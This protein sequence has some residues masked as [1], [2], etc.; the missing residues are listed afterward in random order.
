[1]S[2]REAILRAKMYIDK[3]ANGIDPVTDKKIPDNE[4]IN[5]VKISRCLFFV[6][7]LLQKMA[8]GEGKAVPS[9]MN[10]P[11]QTAKQQTR[12]YVHKE[13]LRIS[14]ADKMKIALSEKPVGITQL[15]ENINAVVNKDKMH[16]LRSYCI[17]EWLMRNKLLA[18]AVDKDGNK[19]KY[20]TAAGKNYGITGVKRSGAKGDYIF[21]TYSLNA[22]KL[23]LKNLDAIIE[24]NNRPKKSF[25]K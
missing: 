4:V 9:Q 5:N 16:E 10:T 25:N 19:Y 18:D 12:E 1:M 2:E 24:I 8:D 3:L 21:V 23:I 14:N 13:K 17:L 11:K 15:A 6:S 20:P 22:Q 7:S